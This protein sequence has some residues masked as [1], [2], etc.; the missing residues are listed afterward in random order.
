MYTLVILVGRRQVT[1]AIPYLD[2]D[3][4]K[5]AVDGFSGCFIGVKHPDVVLLLA[6]T[7]AEK[8]NLA[9]GY[10]L[11]R[12][13]NQ[14]GPVGL[15]PVGIAS[16]RHSGEC[17]VKHGVTHWLESNARTGGYTH[18]TRNVFTFSQISNYQEKK[19]QVLHWIS[20]CWIG[21]RSY[22]NNLRG[23][24]SGELSGFVRFTFL[25]SLAT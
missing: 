21:E 3:S 23:I 25:R 24:A 7:Q 4:Y 14:G 17:H 8:K 12:S 18:F 2:K 13:L 5:M 22:T 15:L 6:I 9:L 10:D 16:Y 19:A 1:V 20:L 11:F